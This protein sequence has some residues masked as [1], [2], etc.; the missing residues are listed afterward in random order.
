M[1]LTRR[2]FIGLHLSLICSAC[3]AEKMHFPEMEEKWWQ[4][5]SNQSK[6]FVDHNSWAY[7]LKKYVIIA[8]DNNH[9]FAYGDVTPEDKE[10]LDVY[11]YNLS[12]FPIENL[13][14]REQYAYWLN[15]YNALTVRLILSH[16]LI[17]SIQDIKFGFPPFTTDAFKEKLID[18]RGVAFSLDDIRYK[19]LLQVFDDPR[20][21]YGLC[22]A[23][24]GSPNIPISPF[25]GDWVD[26]M[27]DGAALDFINDSKGLFIENGALVLS[28]LFHKYSNEFG[29]NKV[30]QLS[31]IKNYIVPGTLKKINAKMPVRYQFDWSLNDGTGMLDQ[32]L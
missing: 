5:Y 2:S 18:I 10:R 32:K 25:T 22:D 13:S 16:Y 24:L 19:V 15:F 11:I 1:T 30:S 3:V 26:R 6:Q 7:L 4:K 20:I 29:R 31:S 27:L 17:L 28:R 12:S 9:L 21:H 23:A 8:S 14:R